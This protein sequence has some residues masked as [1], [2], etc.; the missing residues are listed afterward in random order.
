M[1]ATWFAA[2]YTTTWTVSPWSYERLA[3]GPASQ[4]EQGVLQKPPMLPDEPCLSPWPRF[5]SETACALV[6]LVRLRRRAPL[7]RCPGAR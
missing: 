2:G 4:H 6:L 5:E 7:L 1:V 3:C